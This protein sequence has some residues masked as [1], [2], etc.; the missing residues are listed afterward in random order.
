MYIR[1]TGSDAAGVYYP[2]GADYYHSM[3]MFILTQISGTWYVYF[4]G[5]PAFNGPTNASPL[6]N[7][8]PAEEWWTGTGVAT[9]LTP[10]LFADST[11][12][13]VTLP[14]FAES[15]T[16]VYEGLNADGIVLQRVSGV[17]VTGFDGCTAAEGLYTWDGTAY[18]GP[19]DWRV[20]PVAS[21]VWELT[22]YAGGGGSDGNDYRID[23]VPGNPEGTYYPAMSLLGYATVELIEFWA[24]QQWGSNLYTRADESVTGEY[25]PVS[26]AA[27]GNPVISDGSSSTFTITVTTG[28]NGEVLLNSVLA[29]EGANEVEGGTSPVLSFVPAAGYLI[30]EILIDGSPVDRDWSHQFSG[31]SANHTAEVSFVYDGIR[32]YIAEWDGEP[33]ETD[34]V[35]T[36]VLLYVQPGLWTKSGTGD[37]TDGYLMMDYDEGTP[38]YTIGGSAKTWGWDSAIAGENAPSGNYVPEGTATGLIILREVASAASSIYP[39]IIMF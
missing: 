15:S 21:S 39:Q 4:M 33:G 8:T 19:S 36:G 34:P 26:G 24:I 27:T 14:D 13:S 22:N 3:G 18:R 28:A 35:P 11:G 1:M 9:E 31:I 2:S 20:I 32:N 29:D 6:G 5:S 30:D 10:D 12:C 23:Y 25:E 16:D 38:E 17:L 7:Y 37:T